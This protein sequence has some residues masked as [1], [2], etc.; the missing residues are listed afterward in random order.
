M[1]AGDLRLDQAAT[2]AAFVGT[3]S[4]TYRVDHVEIFI[5]CVELASDVARM[6]S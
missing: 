2:N 6:V 4:R 5:E 1:T 3:A